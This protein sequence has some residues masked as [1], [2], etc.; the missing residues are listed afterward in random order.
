MLVERCLCTS[1]DTIELI[2]HKVESIDSIS[3]KHY[4]VHYTKCNSCNREWVQHSQTILNER[5]YD[6]A[7]IQKKQILM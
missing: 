7:T 6:N 5:L 2:E 1:T 3:S 4:N